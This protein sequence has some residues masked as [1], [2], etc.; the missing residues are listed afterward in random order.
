V[1]TH[2]TCGDD[3]KKKRLCPVCLYWDPRPEEMSGPGL[4]YCSERD[5]VTM[6]RCECEYFE[7]ATRSKVDARNKHLYGELEDEEEEE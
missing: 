3:R 7:E 5:I 1:T 2:T 4:G 6:I